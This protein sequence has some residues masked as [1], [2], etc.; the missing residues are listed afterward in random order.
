MKTW[1]IFAIFLQTDMQNGVHGRL[2]DSS[3]SVREAAVEL[4]G[5][6]ILS[7]PELVSQYYDMLSERILVSSQFWFVSED[8]FVSFLKYSKNV[9]IYMWVAEE[10]KEKED[11][12]HITYFDGVS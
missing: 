7:R 2:L 1:N 11:I 9:K 8:L 6:F 4:I 5:N 3:T 10:K 12:L